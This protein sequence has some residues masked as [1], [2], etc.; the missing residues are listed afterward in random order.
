MKILFIHN[1]YR[2]HG[3]E[4]RVLEMESSLLTQKGHDVQV[5]IFDNKAIKG[6]LANTRSL[7]SSLYNFNSA[8]K[9]V[10]I[11]REFKPDVVH[12][13]NI[14]FIASPSVLVTARKYKIP[15]VFTLHNYRLIC[16]NALM[17]RKNKLCEL[18]IDKKFP[19]AGIR[20]KCYRNSS[21]AT[22]LVTAITGI[23]KYFK[24]WKK[25]IAVFITINETLREKFI[26]SSL[27]IQAEKF[28]T[29][30]NFIPD[31]GEGTFPR[32]DFF[33]FIGR[34]VTEKGVT[35]LLK[36]F[37]GL[38]GKKLI[39]IGDGPE[40]EVLS[41]QYIVCE[42][43]L[44]KGHLSKLQVEEY[45][46]KCKAFICPSLWHEGPPLTVI[47]A[48]AT[49][50]PVIA[51]RLLPLTEVIKDHHNGF[52]FSANDIEELKQKVNLI[53]KCTG[54]ELYKNA[55]Q[56]YFDHFHPDIHYNAIMNIYKTSL[57]S[58]A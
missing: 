35:V 48:L 47:E 49:G 58:N 9:L 15:V 1:R 21:R 40:K 57:A 46:K 34:I 20:Y 54:D 11:I 4:D 45:L 13:H 56:T 41:Q 32:E 55:R 43:I 39:I 19:F 22:A 18:C 6:L 26:R 12:V 30:Q 29:K 23:H 33:L 53:E 42:N 38:P 17:L 10:K 8:R 3:G 31:P 16:A 50:T 52:L 36:A 2:Q 14:F 51:S 7:F 27:E 28:I 5:L 25:S 37:A 24:T 44:F